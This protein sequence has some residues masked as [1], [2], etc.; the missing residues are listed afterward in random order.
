MEIAKQGAVAPEDMRQWFVM[1]HLEPQKLESRFIDI[2]AERVRRNE[3][4]VNY[5]MPY[6]VLER[7]DEGFGSLENNEIRAALRRYVF[8]RTTDGQLQD[9]LQESWNQGRMRLCRYKGQDGRQAVISD[10]MMQRFINI[11]LD[12]RERFGFHSHVPEITKGMEVI[13]RRGAFKD[14]KAEVFGVS[15]TAKGVRLELS[16]EFFAHTQ[17]IHLYDRTLE[18]IVLTSDDAFVIGSDY[19][20]KIQEILLLALEHKV[21]GYKGDEEARQE[22]M[23]KLNMLYLYR[24]MRIGNDR[25]RTQYDALMLL[26]AALR[27]DREGKSLYNA[28]VKSHIKDLQQ[29]IATP[30]DIE[31]ITLL[32]VAL[33]VST[34]DNEYRKQ[35]KELVKQE[36]QN[37]PILLRFISLIRQM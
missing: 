9:I 36:K 21:N 20:S 18:D 22:D 16:V 11:C 12:R 27:Y 37:N 13:I 33:F 30:V 1:T 10:S 25:S 24:H 6:L 29:N 15:H 32:Y 8:L 4:P 14:L 28:I 2:N 17:D 7:L 23:R 26:C 5:F 31:T 34:K 35:A 19:I 3:D